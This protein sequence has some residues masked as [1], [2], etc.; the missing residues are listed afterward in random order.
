MRTELLHDVE[1]LEASLARPGGTHKQRRQI[2]SELARRRWVLQRYLFDPRN[3]WNASSEPVP[4]DLD[5]TQP[6]REPVRR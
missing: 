6:G 5:A 3:T 1:V 2:E 4:A